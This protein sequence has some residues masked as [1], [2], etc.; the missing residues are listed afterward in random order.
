MAIF[1]ESSSD[2][3]EDTTVHNN[4][5]CAYDHYLHLQES[6]R[7][8]SGEFQE[9]FRRASGELQESLSLIHISEPTRLALI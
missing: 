5:G 4:F 1:R 2:N 6:F 7:R 3:M 8:A 9:S